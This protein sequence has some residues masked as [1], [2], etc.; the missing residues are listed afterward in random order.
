[1]IKEEKEERAANRLFRWL[2]TGIVTLVAIYAGM[3]IVITW[4]VSNLNIST[5]GSFGDSFGPLTSMFS[6]V[7]FAGL[8]WTILLQRAELRLQR[9]E[10][11]ESRRQAV[12]TRLMTVTQNQV[13]AYRSEIESLR[14]ASI[15]NPDKEI[16]SA[17]MI[18]LMMAYLE[19]LVQK[20][21]K[22][23]ADGNE[24]AN[25]LHSVAINVRAYQALVQGL[26]RCCKSNHLLLLNE[27][28][29]PEEANDLKS[30]M[31]SELP[32][33]LMDFIRHLH[34]TLLA[35]NKSKSS[36]RSM[37]KADLFD[38]LR[39]ID[40]ECRRILDYAA[41]DFT[42]ANIAADRKQKCLFK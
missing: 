34:T 10:L 7:A 42:Q 4:P 8:I 35:Y 33:G 3:L 30:H 22:G 13:H 11:T 25:Y 29:T 6:G 21:D 18:F 20:Q 17:E 28:I 5:A 36:V 32:T 38:P 27:S 16:G 15:I 12:L 37:S 9:N 31:L 24:I 39:G 23:D 40:G 26:E 41:H 1:M 14:F 2:L 19:Q